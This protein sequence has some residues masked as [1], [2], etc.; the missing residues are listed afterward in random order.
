MQGRT[1]L[2]LIAFVSGCVDQ[3]VE[4][5]KEIAPAEGEN[6][7]ESEGEVGNEHTGGVRRFTWGVVVSTMQLVHESV[8]PAICPSGW[9]MLQSELATRGEGHLPPLQAAYV[10]RF[11][12]LYEFMRASVAARAAL[13][14]IIPVLRLSIVWPCW[15]ANERW[16]NEMG[17]VVQ[18]LVE[19]GWR[20]ELTLLHHDSYPAAL[21][22]AN[23]SGLGGWSNDAATD[24]FTE[25]ARSVSTTMQRILP[26]GSRIYIVNEPEAMLFNGYLDQSGKWPPGGKNAGKSLAKAFLNMRTALREAARIVTEAGFEPAIAI[27]VRPLLD[28]NDTPTERVLEHL[29]NW[30]LADALIRGCNDDSFSWSCDDPESAVLETIG[31]TF[32]GHM[33]ASG[34]T[35]ALTNEV[36]MALPII[37]V[38]PDADLFQLTLEGVYETYGGNVG[39]AEI[40]FTSA[41]SR[42]MER[43]LR[44]YLGAAEL[45]LPDEMPSFIQLHTLFQGAEFSEGDWQFHLLDGCGDEELCEFTPWGMDVFEVILGGY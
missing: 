7:G 15:T 1:F 18:D 25:Y 12:N 29:H 8:D 24:A 34:D 16:R 27:N 4:V 38:Q 44:E 30:W 3:R 19:A 17:Q 43:W 31:L 2:F 6:E 10:N 45:A 5:Q 39:V 9:T 32:Y 22:S 41:R 28:S 11:E 37:N 42:Q 13:D 33:K 14:T 26:E 21:H 20:I 35:V 36:D 40:G 23:G